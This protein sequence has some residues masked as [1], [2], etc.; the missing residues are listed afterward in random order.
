MARAEALLPLGTL[1]PTSTCPPPASARRWPSWPSGCATPIR[2]ADP[3]Y[4][5]QMLKPPHPVAGPRRPPRCCSTRTTTR[6]TAARRLRRW[7]RRPSRSSRA[8]FGCDQHLG[9]LTGVGHDRQPRS[10]LGRARAACRRR[11]VSARTRTTRTRACPRVLGVAHGAVAAATRDGR[12]DLDA[13]EAGWSAGGVGT[14]VATLGTTRL[15]RGRR[16]RRHRRPVR[17]ARRAAARRRR[18]RRVLPAAGRRR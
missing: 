15:G 8:M 10:A 14:V 12:M 16:G 3:H 6:S 1:P 11:V 13:L 18:L 17:R 2:T 4:A 7:R 5:G 9:H